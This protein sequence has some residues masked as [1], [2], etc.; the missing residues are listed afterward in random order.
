MQL[1]IKIEYKNKQ[2]MSITK[3]ERRKIRQNLP[4]GSMKVICES[5]HLSRES[6]FLWFKGLRNNGRIEMFVSDFYKRIE[7]KDRES[8]KRADEFIAKL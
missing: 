6:V 7:E 8:E 4:H 1:N 3:E 5:L 2:I